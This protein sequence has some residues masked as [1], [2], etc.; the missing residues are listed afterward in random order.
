MRLFETLDSNRDRD[1]WKLFEILRTLTDSWRLLETFAEET[2]ET[3]RKTEETLEILRETEIL[4]T[5]RETDSETL[6]DS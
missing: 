2:L 3:L 1:S 5:L 6:R 4:E